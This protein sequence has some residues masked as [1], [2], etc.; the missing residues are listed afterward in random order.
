MSDKTIDQQKFVLGEEEID[1][2]PE[3]LK[4]NEQNIS[5]YYQNEGGNYDYFSSKLAYA[6]FLL[7]RRDLEYDVV[8]N[9]KFATNKELGGSDKYVESKTK[10]DPEVVEAKEVAI[11]AKLKKNLLQQHVRSWDRNHDN[12]L[13]LGHM[14]RKEM[15]KLG[16][17]V[18]DRPTSF[19]NELNLVKNVPE[20]LDIESLKK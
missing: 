10:A 15:E 2:N 19:E 6:D 13:S 17:E 4:F 9:E 5:E 11:M 1:L 8:Y 18:K 3:N 7:A 16:F 20:E 12:A 14:L